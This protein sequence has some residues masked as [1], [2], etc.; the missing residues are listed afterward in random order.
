MHSL[1]AHAVHLR[2]CNVW[3]IQGNNEPPA[4]RSRG[5]HSAR[6]LAKCGQVHIDCCVELGMHA[7]SQSS[8]V[9]FRGHMGNVLL[10]ACSFQPSYNLSPGHDAPV[11]L[12]GAVGERNVQTMR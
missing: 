1:T 11:V 5:S 7:N 10:V 8:S 2:H 3:A 12:P 6:T 9:E 4:G